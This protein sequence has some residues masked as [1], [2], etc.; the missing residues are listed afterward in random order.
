M[1]AALSSLQ[2][3]AAR[4]WA[5]QRYTVNATRSQNSFIHQFHKI[6]KE[7]LNAPLRS[8]P[9]AKTLIFAPYEHLWLPVRFCQKLR[10]LCR[11]YERARYD[12]GPHAQA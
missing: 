11:P 1:L 10:G 9:H 6:D 12:R 3:I 5:E 4:R 7:A 8:I 2:D